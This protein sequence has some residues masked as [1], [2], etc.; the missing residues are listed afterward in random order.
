MME[1][2]AIILLIMASSITIH[3]TALI[4]SIRQIFKTNRRIAWSMI[5][6]VLVLMMARRVTPLYHVIMGNGDVAPDIS[7]E[8]TKLLFSIFVAVGILYIAPLFLKG[9]RARED[10][11]LSE[12]KYRS[13]VENSIEGIYQTTM[14]G[15]FL[16][17]NPALARMFGYASPDEMMERTGD[18]GHQIYVNPDDR[19]RLKR[20]LAEKGRAHDFE[21]EVYRK[22]GSVF[23]VTMNSRAVRNADG[24]IRYIEGSA[25]DIT[26]RKQAELALKESEERYRNLYIN[27]PVML[28]SIDREE[29][30]I[31]ASEQWLNVMGYSREE[32]IGHVF[33][34]FHT[35]ESRAYAERTGMPEFYKTGMCMDVPCQFVTKSGRII[36]AELSAIAERDRQGDIIRSIAVL[37]DVTERKKAEEDL[38]IKSMAIDSSVDAVA[39]SD[40]NGII[41]YVNPAFLKLWGYDSAQ[42]VLGTRA[43]QYR[44]KPSNASE[45]LRTLYTEGSWQ[46]EV[47]AI[48][49]DGDR[50]KVS[51]SS[52][53][54]PGEKGKPIAILAAFLD[55][56][57]RKKREES[58]RSERDR[59]Q[60]LLELHE[61]APEL[62]DREL[63]DF[64]LEK[65]VS[66]TSS[67]IGFFH[68]T[69]EDGKKIILST[70]NKKALETCTVAYGDHYAMEKAGNWV[71]C[72]RLKKPVVYN[73]YNRSP[74]RKGLPDGHT[75]VRRFMSIPVMDGDM[76]RFIIGV[77]N[78]EQDYDEL[79]VIQLQLVAG[80]L[81]KIMQRRKGEKALLESEE[82]FRR[83]T[84][85]VTDYIY[86][87]EVLD[88]LAVNTNHG[89]AC[90]AV[91]GYS[92]EELARDP[93]LWIRMVHEDD[94]EKVRLR[95]ERILS[96]DPSAEFDHRIIRKDGS[97]R[98]VRDTQVPHYDEGGRL[99]SYDGLISDITERKRTE[100]ALVE[101]EKRFRTIIENT[102]AGYFRADTD[103]IFQYVNSAWLKMHGYSS[104][105][106]VIGKHLAIAQVDMDMAITQTLIDKI[107]KKRETENGESSRKNKDGTIG[108]ITYTVNPVIMAGKVTGL[109]GF[110]I[111]ITPYKQMVDALKKSEERF[112]VLF[113][114]MTEGVAIH[115]LVY[116]YKGRPI[117]YIIMDTN[118]AFT[119]HT[120]IDREKIVGKK[121]TYAYG[122]ALPPYFDI[123]EKVAT[124]GEPARFEDYFEPLKKHFSISAFSPAPGFFA[125][126]FED[127]TKRMEEAD[128]L[129]AAKDYAENLIQTA[130]AMIIG[131]DANGNITI[132][133]EAAEKITGYTQEE[134]VGSGWF[135]VLA[136]KD[137]YPAVWDEFNR[138]L[139]NEGPKNFENPILTKTGEEHIIAWQNSALY[140]KGR[141]AGTI[142]FGI[143]ITERKIAEEIIKESLREKEL[144]LKEVHHRVKNNMQIIMSLLRMKA[145][146]VRDPEIAR[147]FQDSQNR[148][149]SMAL[150]HE[151]LYQTEDFTRI[152]FNDYTR[153]LIEE[154]FCMYDVAMNRITYRLDIDDIHMG[155][156]QA[157]PFGL[158]INELVTNA[159]KYAFPAGATDHGE[160]SI[161]MS[162]ANG[163]IETQVSDNGIGI[164]ESVDYR[165]M[166]SSGLTLVHM[167]I[168]KQLQGT[169]KLSREKGTSFSISIPR[170]YR[171]ALHN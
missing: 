151:R 92:A 20:M 134:L 48:K 90:K 130:N 8:L 103:G 171:I 145:D 54:V 93:L 28:F 169:I 50:F 165:K 101:S 129:V 16:M 44:E 51:V 57:E 14:E 108:F 119:A 167:I 76:V 164:L 56:T 140:E 156:D 87:V 40:L 64:V 120:G 94:R 86:T 122:T 104:P 71:D 49:K 148:I 23:L 3:A 69:T 63:Y 85:S 99:V 152:D 19:E 4:M 98:W 13:I 133:N 146:K 74:N 39:I 150:I 58:L 66:L 100:E 27:T 25:I 113:E 5:T 170:D 97:L 149:Y 128:A 62:S 65:A 17:V 33:L 10:L 11:K 111:D 162:K 41:T 123:Y 138:V 153:S 72:I 110:L 61:R 88:G 132:F 102:G 125:T 166:E 1:S 135:E 52:N 158:V 77:G 112:R 96:G 84:N 53:M 155:I 118:P 78:K 147:L 89:A 26:E 115:K 68:Q 91:T 32:V 31:G 37:N 46:G 126:V 7:Y 114:T 136:P 106:E 142:S 95:A 47:T 127:I 22:D 79:D 81:D 107:L 55:I 34:E 116:N 24:K 82:R 38:Q 6:I 131:L 141:P 163:S 139:S 43:R 137:R 29:R 35:E 9:E 42:E 21:A 73:D 59:A 124:T 121:A 83:I 30:I 18:I 80:E 160:I 67:E 109:E 36:E 70:W 157:I 159:I 45:I 117:D 154:L 12:E 144:L 60:I 168:E 143:D 2:N 161:R 105:R 15:R 75:P